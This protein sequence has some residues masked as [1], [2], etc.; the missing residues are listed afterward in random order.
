M[1]ESTEKTDSG[2]ERCQFPKG[3]CT[4]NRSDYDSS[5]SRFAG[6]AS[7]GF[8]LNC[9]R[10]LLIVFLLVAC[11]AS[12]AHSQEKTGWGLSASIG[13]SQVKDVDSSDTFEGSA[14][15]YSFEGEYRFTPYFAAGA[16]IFSLG[17]AEDVFEG[18]DTELDA[19]GGG[20]FAR[21]IYPVSETADLY[22]RLGG[23]LYTADLDPGGITSL[24]GE[25]ALEL[26][27]GADFGGG[28]NLAFRIEGR[29]FKG[30]RDETG[31]LLT[32]GLS[33]RF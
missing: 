9:A 30:N 2:A 3:I 26:G 6:A 31:S 20:V 17:T 18:V 8:E 24:F 4:V 25:D 16:G 13:Y 11:G 28:G 15:G 12:T 21:A 32:I 14:F 7:N 22:A 23:V 5:T 29:Y 33:Y 10:R 27:L 19:Q 1:Q